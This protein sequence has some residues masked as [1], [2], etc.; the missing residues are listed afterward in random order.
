[1][2]YAEMSIL[3]GCILGVGW[4]LIDS[5]QAQQRQRAKAPEQT[6]TCYMHG[7]VTEQLKGISTAEEKVSG[8]AWKLT[9]VDGG[10]SIY[11][12]REGESCQSEITTGK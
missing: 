7:K 3:L 4:L 11:A 12:Q 5:A 9:Y 6:F 2:R 1:M 8:P 10:Y